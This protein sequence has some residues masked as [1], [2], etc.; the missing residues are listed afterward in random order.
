MNRVYR[1]TMT[2]DQLEI[3]AAAL[4]EY[5]SASVGQWRNLAGRL[6]FRGVD[7]H[8]CSE[9]AVKRR[10][11][12]RNAAE[13]VFKAASRIVVDFPVRLESPPNEK[14]AHDMNRIIEDRLGHTKFGRPI[15]R[16]AHYES[17]DTPITVEVLSGE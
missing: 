12:K 5:Y 3:I 1:L 9:E 10:F 11:V 15:R 13:E 8:E 16:D 4:D 7:F 17:D 14:S 6:A 2:E